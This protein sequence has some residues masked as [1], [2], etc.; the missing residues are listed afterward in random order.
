MKPLETLKIKLAG[1]SAVI[2]IVGFHRYKRRLSDGYNCI[3]ISPPL[4]SQ[5]F[6]RNT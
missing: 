2:G 3:V 1:S 6:L 5:T 4:E